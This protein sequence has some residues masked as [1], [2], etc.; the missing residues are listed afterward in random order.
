MFYYRIVYCVFG[1]HYVLLSYC[2]LCI[3]KSLCFIIVLCIVYLEI[4]MFYYRFIIDALHKNAIKTTLSLKKNTPNDILYVESGLTSLKGSVYKRQYKFWAKILK[5]IAND[6]HSSI[7]Q[8]YLQ[9]IECAIYQ[10]LCQAT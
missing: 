1:N 8:I 2:V 9:A 5:D 3:W 7:M 6:R 10:T 4:I